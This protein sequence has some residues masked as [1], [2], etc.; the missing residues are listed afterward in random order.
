VSFIIIIGTLSLPIFSLENRLLNMDKNQ[1]TRSRK[2][3]LT[4]SKR[5]LGTH[6]RINNAA[7][8]WRDKNGYSTGK[9][10]KCGRDKVTGLNRLAAFQRC[11]Y[12]SVGMCEGNSARRRRRLAANDN[13]VT[14]TRRQNAQAGVPANNTLDDYDAGGCGHVSPLRDSLGVTD[15]P[16]YSEQ[17]AT[18]RGVTSC[19]IYQITRYY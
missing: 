11:D 12:L 17:L 19:R 9:T 7:K 18:L 2:E 13:N 4:N 16:R 1:W 6:A 3:E 15:T 5:R 10:E 14:H 8:K